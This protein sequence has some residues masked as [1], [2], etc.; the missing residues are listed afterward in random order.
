MS[1]PSRRDFLKRALAG[2]CLP[3]LSLAA[4]PAWGNSDP[5]THKKPL[6]TE[7]PTTFLFG[8]PKFLGDAWHYYPHNDSWVHIVNGVVRDRNPPY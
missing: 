6:Q 1:R 5:V 8:D 7:P 2:L 4:A 3:G